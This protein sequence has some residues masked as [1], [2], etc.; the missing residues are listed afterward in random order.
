[1]AQRVEYLQSHVAD[2]CRRTPTCFNRFPETTSLT[3]RDR[4]LGPLGSPEQNLEL[5][6]AQTSPSPEG[7]HICEHDGLEPHCVHDADPCAGNGPCLNGGRCKTR[8]RASSQ[9]P[10]ACGCSPGSGWAGLAGA[11]EAGKATSNAEGVACLRRTRRWDLLEASCDCV[12][13]YGGDTCAAAASDGPDACGCQLGTGWSSSAN[14]GAGGCAAG[15]STSNREAATCAQARDG[16]DACGCALGTGWSKSAQ[17]CAEGGTTSSSEAE[18][19]SSGAGGSGQAAS[20]PPPRSPGGAG[21]VDDADGVMAAIGTDCATIVPSGPVRQVKEAFCGSDLEALCPCFSDLVARGTVVSSVCQVSCDVEP[22]DCQAQAAQP[23]PS[24]PSAMASSS[25]DVASLA[26]LTA[27]SCPLAGSGSWTPS[28]CPIECARVFD[29]WW[30]RCGSQQEFDIQ[31]SVELGD[32]D[33]AL[34][35]GQFARMC[36]AAVAGQPDGGGH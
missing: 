30:S 31:L 36:A 3:C 2:E 33:A 17:A 8:V 15:S 13:G 27:D 19:C 35:F 10:D 22:A 5:L 21:C 6:C 23:D 7:P 26:K 29:P 16:P 34:V 1:M 11:C 18:D 14:G 9:G 32:P 12:S 28:S 4:G 24:P 20:P 25:C